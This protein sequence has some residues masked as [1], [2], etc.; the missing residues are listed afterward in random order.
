MGYLMPHE[1]H[2]AKWPTFQQVKI[3]N[4]QH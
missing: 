4:R 3:K 2:D 1:A